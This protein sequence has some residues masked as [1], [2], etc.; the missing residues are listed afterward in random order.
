MVGFKGQVSVKQYL[1]LKPVKRGIKFGSV[2]TLQM[3]TFV[4]FKFTRV[5]K[6]AV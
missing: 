3:A 1:P 4:I 6:M 5:N 2:P